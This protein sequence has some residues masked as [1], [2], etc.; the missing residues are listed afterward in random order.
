MLGLNRK[1]TIIPYFRGKEIHSMKTI[2]SL[3]ALMAGLTV[4]FAVANGAFA[5]GKM[6]QIK[7]S[8]T[9]VNL[10]SNL[11][12]A[13]MQAHTDINIA[14]TGGGSG[15]GIAA[16]LNGTTEICA[17]SRMLKEEENDQAAAK[18]VKPVSS[19]IGLDG[20]AVM[21]N[22]S[23]PI[24]ELTLEQLKNIY[25]G[26]YT[27]WSDVGGPDQPMI[28]LSRESNSGTYVYFQEHVLE[29]KDYSPKV[30]LMPSTAAI[31]K[32]VTDDQWSIGYGGVAYAEHAN[33]KTI[34]VKKTTDAPAIAPTEAT[35]HD[36]S[37]PI[38]RPLFLFT[39]GEPT[40]DVKA[41]IDFC[42][43]PAGQKIVTETGYITVTH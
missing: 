2:R 29:K 27:R 8:D 19:T 41:F 23:N 18:N 40:G 17:S 36:G 43:S 39:N 13:Y 30:R 15:T 4:L 16:L 37:Y 25:T 6:I 5:A 26:A 22:T 31:T 14:V 21:V 12:E 33:V 9:M 28:V 35:V 11:A 10:M 32:S 42:N 20:I 34:K 24:S 7:G 1:L 3:C 38:S